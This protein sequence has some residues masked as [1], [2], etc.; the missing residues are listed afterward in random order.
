MGHRPEA[1]GWADLNG[2]LCQSTPSS[3]SEDRV[4]EVKLRGF[5]PCPCFAMWSL[6]QFK[7]T[8]ASSSGD[9][10]QWEIVCYSQF[11]REG[12]IPCHAGPHEKY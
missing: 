5:L 1:V 4:G 2:C 8:E 12:D 3:W 9:V 11:L 6:L 10:F 7:D